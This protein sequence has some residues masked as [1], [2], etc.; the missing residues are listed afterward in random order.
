[1][2]NAIRSKEGVSFPRLHAVQ[3]GSLHLAQLMD[4][5]KKTSAEVSLASS[6]Y[7]IHFNF[8]SSIT[9]RDEPR[10]LVIAHRNPAPIVVGSITATNLGD[11][12]PITQWLRQIV[13][14]PLAREYERV[15]ALTTHPNHASCERIEPDS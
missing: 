5:S 14:P 1:M 3:L 9:L 2:R 12:L 11:P 7:L 4:I 6:I 10:L 13:L 8:R 15:K